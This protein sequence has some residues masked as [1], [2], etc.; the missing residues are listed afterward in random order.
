[1][2]YFSFCC[3]NKGVVVWWWCAGGRVEGRNPPR[4]RQ[5]AGFSG[6]NERS[7]GTK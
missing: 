4:V 2:W 5:Q 6:R 1:M 7:A 3:G